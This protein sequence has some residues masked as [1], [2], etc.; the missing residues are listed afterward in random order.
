MCFINGVSLI[1]M[2]ETGA[3]HSF[4]SIDCARKLNL[5]VS[6]KVGSIVIDTHLMVR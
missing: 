5:D 4:I 2:I 3:K 1:A 6:S